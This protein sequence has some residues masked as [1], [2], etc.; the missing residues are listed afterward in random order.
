MAQ[1]HKRTSVIQA[2][3]LAGLAVASVGFAAAAQPAAAQ[4]KVAMLLPGS[5]NDQSWNAQGYA[6]LMK[7]KDS[8]YQTAYSENVPAADHVEA[9]RDYARQGFKIVIG[10]SGRFLSAAQRV[11]PEFPE[12]QFIAGAGGA[13]QGKNVMS[14]D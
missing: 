6:G 9:M 12:V 2:L 7:I 14:I 13:G 5:I 3:R 4:M 10:H 8:G 1:Q 11:G